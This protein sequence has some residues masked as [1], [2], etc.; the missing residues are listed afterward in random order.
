MCCKVTHFSSTHVF[1]GNFAA[2]TAQRFEMSEIPVPKDFAAR[3]AECGEEGRQLLEAL[4]D[5]PVLSVHLNMDK[6]AVCGLDVVKSAAGVAWAENGFYLASRP[7]FTFDPLLHAGAYYVEEPSSMFV[8]RALHRAMQE[9]DVNRVLDLCAAPGGKSLML[10]S[11]MRGGLLVANE[12]IAKRTAVLAENVAKWGHPDVVVTRNWPA[13]FAPLQGFFDVVAADVPCSGEGMFR[14]DPEARLQWTPEAVEACAQRQ[15][16][17]VADVWPALR[18]GGFL[19][20]S[21]CTFNRS[22]NEDNVK[23]I[24]E[25]LGAEPVAIEKSEEWNIVGDT[26][27]G[28]LPVCH[29]FPHRLRGE[30]FFLALLRKM[31]AEERG[32]GKPHPSASSLHRVPK[33]AE[34]RQ[35]L[36]DSEAFEF[37]DDGQGQFAVHRCFAEDFALLSL[38]ANV[39]SAGI[40]LSEPKTA[41]K[42]SVS[43]KGGA[44]A[45]RPAAPLAL[46]QCLKADA[47]PKVEL[48]Y[49]D[50]I[51]FLRGESIA[52]PANSARGWTL[53]CYRGLPLGFANN[54]GARL[55]NA[56]PDQW[57]IRSTYA[58]DEPPVLDFLGK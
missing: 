33:G 53:V 2:V 16:Q 28:T 41:A 20:Y 27:G 11:A 5:D 12:P 48:G 42:P 40:R 17:I 34:C 9:T 22:E 46:S 35:W 52:A 38:A 50:A 14:K 26:T 13:D 21:T 55:N 4:E 8:A 58:P 6:C 10:R 49:G 39:V 56:F 43:R 30:G 23:W 25:Q 7:R 24:M 3:L 29:F 18:S 57:R 37:F 36:S 1:L 47:F 15:R 51:R 44:Q 31:P 19:I 32:S 45:L 54:V